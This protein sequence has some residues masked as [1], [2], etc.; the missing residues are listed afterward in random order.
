[1]PKQ[2]QIEENIQWPLPGR[3]GVG[4]RQVLNYNENELH[5]LGNFRFQHKN[6]E[7]TP[8]RSKVSLFLFKLFSVIRDVR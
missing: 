3:E 5:N 4:S 1:M 8:A 7:T 2:D 6:Y